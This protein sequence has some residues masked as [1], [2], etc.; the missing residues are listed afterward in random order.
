MRRGQANRAAVDQRHAPARRQ[1]TPNTPHPLPRRAR[2]HQR[3][4]SSNPPATAYPDTAA[5]TGFVSRILVGPIGPSA[6]SGSTICRIDLR[7]AVAAA[8]TA[9]AL[10]S[11]Q[12]AQKVPPSPHSTATSRSVI[13]LEGDGK[14]RRARPPSRGPRHC[15]PAAGS[16]TTVVTASL[17]L[18][19]YVRTVAHFPLQNGLASGGNGHKPPSFSPSVK[20]APVATSLD[21]F[22]SRRTMTVGSKTYAYFSLTAAEKN[23][24]KGISRLPYSLKILLSRTC[25]ATRTARPSMP[26]D[27]RAI[28]GWLEKKKLRSRDRFPSRARADAGFDLWRR[29]PSSILPRCATR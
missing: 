26:T 3:Q 11:A 25:C 23:G 1:K 12:L 20:G 10:R 24:L 27:I 7:N 8:H 21:T 16:S 4:A 19:I 5:I 29:P 14:L 6:A 2:S 22:K 9:T 17:A 18:D 13:F 28:A 15:A